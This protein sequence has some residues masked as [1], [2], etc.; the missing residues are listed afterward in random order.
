MD[1]EGSVPFAAPTRQAAANIDGIKTD[2]MSISF[3][4]K[5]MITIT[6]NGRLAQW[7]TV[8]LLSD[9]PTDSDPYFQTIRSEDD[10]LLPSARF[11]PRTLL[12]AGGSER[13]MMG[14]L[15]ASQIA[16]A[17]TTKTPT[18]SRA[19][20]LGLGLAKVDTDRDYFLQVV[21]LVLNVI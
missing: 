13:E 7:V 8:P 4:D 9:N 21:D 15:F 14:Q 16:H 1:E 12:G 2:V 5:I 3:A 20:M 17:I 11:A 6:Q 18:E 10:A 19:L